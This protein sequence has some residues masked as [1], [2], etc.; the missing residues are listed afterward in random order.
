MSKKDELMPPDDEGIIELLDLLDESDFDELRLEM[1][2]L[3]LIFS[4][5]AIDLPDQ[6]VKPT[7]KEANAPVP[8]ERPKSAESSQEI[9]TEIIAVPESVLQRA[10]AEEAVLMEEEG[11]IPINSPLLGIFYRAP[12]PGAPPFVEIGSYV[13]E[14]DT[15]CLVEVMKLFNTVKAGVKGRIAKICVENNQVVEY[16]QTVFLV[17]PEEIP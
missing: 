3:K 1:S 16:N 13:T 10:E 4:K 5:G 6:T 17:E 7:P 11:L 9:E 2:G 12:K 15:V 14:D 8:N